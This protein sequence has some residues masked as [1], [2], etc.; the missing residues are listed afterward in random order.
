VRAPFYRSDPGGG[1]DRIGTVGRPARRSHG[2][3]DR[4]PGERLYV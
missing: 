2:A 4:R 1:F 3:R